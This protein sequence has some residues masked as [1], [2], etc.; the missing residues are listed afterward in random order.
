MNSDATDLKEQLVAVAERLADD[1]VARRGVSGTGSEDPR[2]PAR[3]K[4]QRSGPRS[5][6]SLIP[7]WKLP[8][9]LAQ[10]LRG[11][12]GADDAFDHDPRVIVAAVKA[13][14]R[15]LYA[16]PHDAYDEDYSE[17]GTESF[18]VEVVSIW[19]SVRVPG[20]G[21]LVAALHAA[22]RDPVQ[23]LGKLAGLGSMVCLAASIAYHLQKYRGDGDILLP[24]EELGRLMGIHHT[25]VSAIVRILIQHHVVRAR[26][27]HC[28]TKRL[29]A[30]Y[31]FNFDSP[32]YRP[33]HT[34]GDP[35]ASDSD[36]ENERGCTVC[37][38]PGTLDR[39][40]R[41]V[42]GFGC[43][44]DQDDPED[45]RPPDGRSTGIG[46]PEPIFTVNDK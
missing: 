14:C 25:R 21:A 20:D 19:N 33:P 38:E 1:V 31:R 5:S 10:R 28:F 29:A 41:C 34:M 3:N 15:H 11:V 8:F 13:L 32:L 22:A 42:S 43:A 12:P 7:A 18:F 45:D 44:N 37:N 17:A 26:A 39:S 27:E 23:L 35:V 46:G 24:R 16:H 2:S 6:G 40:G 4:R 36:V 9:T 30:T